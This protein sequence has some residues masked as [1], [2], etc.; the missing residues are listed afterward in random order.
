M[1]AERKFALISSL[2][3][4][5]LVAYTLVRAEV[6]G[7]FHVKDIDLVIFEESLKTTLSGEGFF[8]N[9]WEWNHWRAWSHFGTHNSP[10]L[11]LLLPVYA[12]FPSEYTLM[13]LQDLMVPLSAFALFSFARKVLGDEEK[14]LAVSI[15]FLLNPLTHAIVRYDFR[16][17]VLA[18]PFMFLFASY[19]AEGKTKKQLLAALLILSVKEDAGLFLVAYS[20][21]EVLSKHGF[22]VKGWLGEKKVIGFA[23][24]GL[25]WIAVSIFLVIPNFNESHEYFYF[26]LYQPGGDRGIILLVALAKLTVLML[27]L[28]FLPLKK[29]AYW[30]PLAFLW[31][32][33]AFAK[34]LEQAA[35]GFQ[36]DYQLLPMAFIVLVYALRENDTPRTTHLLVASLLSMLLFSPSFGLIDAYPLT[37]GHS[38]WEYLRLLHH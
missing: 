29:P 24:L 34:R 32:E 16:P 19:A 17:D 26:M 27:S 4:A 20:I 6:Y 14:A 23:L 28:A 25:V 21:F 3:T 38:L 13:I 31:S 33:N 37:I 36:Y 10:I 35:I 30:L 18:V 12:L 7:V 5:L 2:M 11:F 9:H 15:A 1:R 8:F 22:N